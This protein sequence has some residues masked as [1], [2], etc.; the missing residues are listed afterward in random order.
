M[1]CTR[2]KA[3]VAPG[4][5]SCPAC[6]GAIELTLGEI[7]RL[8]LVGAI[9]R[10]RAGG[11]GTVA[12]F[13]AFIAAIATGW[14]A[15][16]GGDSDDAAI[17]ASVDRERSTIAQ[18]RPLEARAE[19]VSSIVEPALAEPATAVSKV[20]PW[21][22]TFRTV[23]DDYVDAIVEQPDGRLVLLGRT[24]A[25][26]QSANA[27]ALFVSVDETGALESEA[28]LSAFGAVSALDAVTAPNETVYVAGEAAGVVSVLRVGSA[29]DMI[30]GETLQA[31][32]SGIAP[33]A[34]SLDDD[35]L[36]AV[37]AK[38]GGGIQLVR[39]DST[40]KET[41]R[42][43][44]VTE[45]LSGRLTLGSINGSAVLGYS[46]AAEDDPAPVARLVRLSGTGEVI[47]SSQAGRMAGQVDQSVLAES[48]MVYA[49]GTGQGLMAGAPWIVGIAANGERSWRV[50]FED[51]TV[52]SP[53]ALAVSPS[54]GVQVAGAQIRAG[55]S[56]IWTAEFDANGAL[57]WDVVNE[58]DAIEGVGDMTVLP[59]GD[60]IIAGGV[61]LPNAGDDDLLAMRLGSG[62]VP[63]QAPGLTQADTISLTV[64]LGLASAAPI[65]VAATD[66][67]PAP[68][69]PVGFN[70][71]ELETEP[72]RENRIDEGSREIG[73]EAGVPDT[74]IS[75]TLN[76]YSC[77]FRCLAEPGSTIKY[78][79]TQPYENVLETDPDAFSRAIAPDGDFA[80]TTSGGVAEPGALPSCSASAP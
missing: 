12:I 63:S 69:E 3:Q 43:L 24:S 18:M 74:Q 73:T 75:A 58:T 19:T 45:R 20:E 39:F 9:R 57:L 31:A 7:S 37:E 56:D 8:M 60:A 46:D 54:G 64:D 35:V 44:I 41:W 13:V 70:F 28:I 48:G 14:I 68:V 67:L 4:P 2:C 10:L 49:A 76:T 66:A 15:F 34:A 50:D 78:P 17:E 29:G 26:G 59:N 62:G 6:G 72:E 16:G 1:R 51:M 77:V 80:C 33:A 22:R 65:T 27:Q 53:L 40:G 71:P 47:W 30:W 11:A 32:D 25:P 55:A 79:V 36:V 42:R 23:G 21:A 5:Q 38:D 61:R 52:S